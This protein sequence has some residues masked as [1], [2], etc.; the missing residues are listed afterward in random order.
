M[1]VTIPVLYLPGELAVRP[2][3]WEKSS[4]ESSELGCRRP[5]AR[6]PGVFAETCEGLL[7]S[8]PASA[9]NLLS[10]RPQKKGGFCAPKLSARSP[11]LSCSPGGGQWR[12]QEVTGGETL[13][14][15]GVQKCG[16][17][18]SFFSA[19]QGSGWG[20]GWLLSNCSGDT[21]EA[22]MNICLFL[23]IGLGAIQ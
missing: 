18:R 19:L 20:R 23:T 3:S 5:G 12:G 22:E 4:A 21:P 9:T 13:S 7:C 10:H 16:G 15:V 2:P 1:P 17:G 14:A 8:L 6:G 11:S